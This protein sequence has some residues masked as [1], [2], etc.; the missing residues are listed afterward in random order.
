MKMREYVDGIQGAGSW[1]RMH[2]LINAGRISGW[3][4]PPIEI[5]PGVTA[6]IFPGTDREVTLEAVKAE[7]SKAFAQIEAGTATK[8]D[9]FPEE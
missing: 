3:R 9:T 8:M 5:E 7:M 6:H 1:D 4:L 2:D